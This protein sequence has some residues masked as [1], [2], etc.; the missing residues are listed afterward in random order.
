MDKMFERIKII[1]INDHIWLLDD[2]GEATGYLITGTKKALVIDTMN[3]YE[4]VKEVAESITKL[5]LEVVNTHGHPD[6]TYGNIYFD[7]VYIHPAD[8]KVA[9]QYFKDARFVEITKRLGLKPA[10][11][12]PIREGDCFDLGG[13]IIEVIELPGHTPGGIVLLDRKDRILFTGDSII[14]QTWMQLEESLPME[15]FL[16]SLDKIQKLRGA[17][18]YLLTGHNQELIDAK[19]CEPHR[20]AVKEVCM[21]DRTGDVEYTWFGG[22]CMAHPYGPGIHRIVYQPESC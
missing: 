6:H 4:N 17:F 22:K 20:N 9:N 3:G 8:I 10:T 2:N 12:L 11:F 16:E 5:P 18:D 1:P 15:K 19:M 14:E 21:G 13:M 7:E